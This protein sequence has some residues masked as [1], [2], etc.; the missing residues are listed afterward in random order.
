MNN[1]I[2]NPTP[3]S[4]FTSKMMPY[5]TFLFPPFPLWREKE[6]QRNVDKNRCCIYPLVKGQVPTQRLKKAG[7]HNSETLLPKTATSGFIY[8][9]Y[10]LFK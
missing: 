4:H 5:Y 2:I 3:Y 10:V 7:R 9:G 1:V 6:P 8:K